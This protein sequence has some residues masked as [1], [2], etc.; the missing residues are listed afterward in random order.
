M[1][2]SIIF[3][4]TGGDSFVVGRGQR[5]SAGFILQVGDNQFHVDPGNGAT[6]AAKAAD[7]NVRA[8]T[9]VFVT[10]N[11]IHHAS[12]LNSLLDAMTYGGFDTKGVLVAHPDVINV[13][14]DSQPFLHNT[15]RNLL[16]RYI[17]LQPGKRVGINEVE[18]QALKT[19]FNNSIGLKFFLPTLT[20]AY[21]GD[22]KYSVDVAEQYRDASILILNV[23]YLKKDKANN[24]L[25]LE[26]AKSIVE[27]I[28]PKLTIITS[29]GA[30]MQNEDP[31]Y[32]VREI[33][34]ATQTQVIAANDGLVINPVS[35][36]ADIGQWTLQ[37][38]KRSEDEAVSLQVTEPA[39]EEPSP[40]EAETPETAQPHDGDD[41]HGFLFTEVVGGKTKPKEDSPG[42]KEDHEEQKK[43]DEVDEIDELIGDA[44][45]HTPEEDR[46]SE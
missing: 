36:A 29:I 16:E 31:I 12:G 43:L 17:S 45:E 32:A 18:I 8:T 46:K 25:S 35:Y 40:G 41:D 38:Y 28:K 4:G 20:I 11:T 9:S 42:S 2:A 19:T 34:R 7:I 13:R 21:A 3:L 6:Q 24:G 26:E 27:R 1:R 5:S 10:R 37:G 23:P 14:E 22:T 30:E 44:E 39:D 15:C 33:Q